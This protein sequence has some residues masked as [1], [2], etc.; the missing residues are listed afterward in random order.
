MWQPEFEPITDKNKVIPPDLINPHYSDDRFEKDQTIFLVEG[1][2]LVET[3]F[4]T[5][6]V[7]DAHYVYSDR[8]VQSAGMSRIEAASDEAKKTAAPGT[9]SYFEELLKATLE[10]P[11]IDLQHILAGVN[12]SN[13]FSYRIFGTVSGVP[14]E[15]PQAGEIAN[16]PN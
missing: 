5:E 13:G 7:N 12:R 11:T 15:S 9:A 1:I 4:G 6:E 14:N 2:E 16:T 10:D 3:P 8:L